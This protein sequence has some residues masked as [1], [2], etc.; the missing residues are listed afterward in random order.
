VLIKKLMFIISPL[1]VRFPSISWWATR[2][3][4]DINF[5]A[6]S[7][8]NQPNAHIIAKW[9]L[10]NILR[11]PQSLLPKV[12]FLF[13]VSGQR[14]ERT[15]LCYFFS[16]ESCKW[17]RVFYFCEHFVTYKSIFI[18]FML[19]LRKTKE[20]LSLSILMKIFL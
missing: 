1:P 4:Q 6:V 7:V 13:G 9:A 17:F 8:P 11:F 3:R 15:F 10:L 20:F 12:S 16:F 5:M 14:R 19:D 2:R 18:L